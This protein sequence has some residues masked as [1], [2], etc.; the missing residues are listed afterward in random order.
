M[1][2]GEARA[3]PA[4]ATVTPAPCPNCDS[5][6]ENL[7]EYVTAL[8][9]MKQKIV[10]TDHI[11]TEYQKKCDELQKTERE[12]KT[13]RHQMD[14]LLEKC[15][16]VEKCKDE[17]K[18]MRIELEEKKS[19]IK[20]YQQNYSEYTVLKQEQ[21]KHDMLKKKLEARLK[22]LEETTTK[23]NA[24]LKAVKKEKLSLE[25]ALRK[26]QKKLM[27]QQENGI[28]VSKQVQN[29][30]INEQALHTIDKKK[31]KEL[32][33]EVWKCIE[34]P[35]AQTTPD[36]EDV[37]SPA[38]RRSSRIK[39]K[40]R[41]SLFNPSNSSPLEI[42]EL[43]KSL[44]SPQLKCDDEE[45]R[46]H[47]EVDESMNDEGLK[48]ISDRA[49]Y[50]DRTVE[51][52]I[53]KD[54][55][56]CQYISG[57]DTDD[58]DDA[59]QESLSQQ[60]Q[61]ILDW[62]EPLPPQLSPLPCSPSAKEA[63]LSKVQALFG[64]ITDSSDDEAGDVSGGTYNGGDL[65]T[66]TA[67]EPLDVSV[68][69]E[70]PN[71][72]QTPKVEAIILQSVTKGKP[73]RKT[74][75]SDTEMGDLSQSS[76]METETESKLVESELLVPC[77]TAGEIQCKNLQL[78]DEKEVESTVLFQGDVKE[79]NAPAISETQST[80]SAVAHD[81][82]YKDQLP[83]PQHDHGNGGSSAHVGNT[84]VSGDIA[85][86]LISSYQRIELEH[87]RTMPCRKEENGLEAVLQVEKEGE[88][89]LQE[90]RACELNTE[91]M[92]MEE[93]HS[94][95]LPFDTEWVKASV[96]PFVTNAAQT[97]SMAKNEGDEVPHQELESITSACDPIELDK[98]SSTSVIEL[99]GVKSNGFAPVDPEY[100]RRVIPVCEMEHT[101]IQFM[102]KEKTVMVTPLPK[103][104]Y[105]AMTDVVEDKIKECIFRGKNE[106][107]EV[108]SNCGMSDSQKY[109]CRVTSVQ[110]STEL[111][112]TEYTTKERS[113]LHKMES[114]ASFLQ[115]FDHYAAADAAQDQFKVD[116]STDEIEGA[117]LGSFTPHSQN[118]DKSEAMLVEFSDVKQSEPK[119]ER[120][121]SQIVPLPEF[122]CSVQA[123][124]AESS[125]A[126]VAQEE[127][128]TRE[129][130]QLCEM[131]PAVAGRQIMQIVSAEQLPLLPASDCS[132]LSISAQNNFKDCFSNNEVEEVNPSSSI[133]AG[134]DAKSAVASAHTS[135]KQN[136]G[137]FTMREEKDTANLMETLPASDCS[138]VAGLAQ[139]KSM[140]YSSSEDLSK[141]R[142]EPVEF[143][144][145]E[146]LPN[147]RD[148]SVMFNSTEDPANQKDKSVELSS[149]EDLFNQSVKSMEHSFTEQLSHQCEQ[150]DLFT[151]ISEL[152]E[153]STILGVGDS[154]KGVLVEMRTVEE[155]VCENPFCELNE[156]KDQLKKKENEGSNFSNEDGAPRD[157]DNQSSSE[158]KIT[159][160]VR[161]YT[162]ADESE[163][164]NVSLDSVGQECFTEAREKK[165]IDN[166]TDNNVVY[167]KLN[168]NP[169]KSTDL[170]LKSREVPFNDQETL[171]LQPL[172]TAQN[173]ETSEDAQS[174]EPEKPVL[175]LK[176]RSKKHSESM[177]PEESPVE[178]T[179]VNSNEQH[180]TSS[181]KEAGTETA[182]TTENTNCWSE[183]HKADHDVDRF[184]DKCGELR[185]GSQNVPDLKE[186]IFNEEIVAT[187][188][189]EF[190]NIPLDRPIQNVEWSNMELTETTSNLLQIVCAV[191]EL[192]TDADSKE[193]I[194][195]DEDSTDAI[196][197]GCETPPINSGNSKLNIHPIET[198]TEL[199]PKTNTLSECS[200]SGKS[201]LP[202][203]YNSQNKSQGGMDK[204]A[205]SCS[206]TESGLCTK[207]HFSVQMNEENTTTVEEMPGS[208]SYDQIAD[209]STHANETEKKSCS[210]MSTTQKVDSSS[211][212]ELSISSMEHTLN[213]NRD[214]ST[215]ALPAPE[216]E[217][218]E[219]GNGRCELETRSS[220]CSGLWNPTFLN[221]AS[222]T[223]AS[224]EPSM[225]L[226]NKVF[227]STL[228]DPMAAN[229]IEISDCEPI[230][231]KTRKGKKLRLDKDLLL[232]STDKIQNDQQTGSN[233]KKFKV[234]TVKRRV[235]S[236]VKSRGSDHESLLRESQTDT[237]VSPLSAGNIH[238][239]MLE[240]GQPLPPLLAPLV[241]TPPRTTA[242]IRPLIL[243]SNVRSVHSP[244]DELSFSSVE[245]P[246]PCSVSPLFDQARQKSP[247]VHSPSPLDFARNERIQS[248]PLQFCTATPKHAVP[249][250][251][252]LPQSASATVATSLPQENSVKILDAMYPNLS[253][254]ARTL[255]ILRGNVQLSMRGP[256]DGESQAGAVNQI[257]GFKAINSTATAFVKAGNN[258]R[259][260]CR[261]NKERATD[262]EQKQ[263]VVASVTEKGDTPKEEKVAAKRAAENL[264]GKMPKKIKLAQG[265]E[266]ADHPSPIVASNESSTAVAAGT[267]KPF[268]NELAEQKP[269]NK[270]SPEP[271]SL[272]PEQPVKSSEEAVVCALA[273][274]AQSCF[275]LLPV[276]RSHIFVGNIPSLPVLRDE[277]K[278]VISEFSENKELSEALLLAIQ[279]KLKTERLTL[280]INYLHAL[281]RV[282][283]AICRQQGDLERARI[284]CFDILRE[285]F[286]DSDK[287]ILFITSVWKNIFSMRG[288][289][290][291]AMQVVARQRAKDDVL[292]CLTVY[293]D[294]QKN[295]PLNASQ[296]VS[297]FL[298]AM[299]RSPTIKFQAH[300]ELGTDFNSVMWEL[301]FAIDLL[302]SQQPWCLT[303]DNV[304]SK[305][306]WPLM[307]K[308]VK[309]RKGK[310]YVL[311]IQDV[312]VG[313]VLR[314]I[315][316][317]GKHGI[318]KGYTSKVK[319]LS[320]VM[321]L[322]LQQSMKEGVPWSV[323]IAA[324][325]AVYEL[326]PSNLEEALE[327]LKGW[328]ATAIEALPSSVSQYIA[329]LETFC[330]GLNTTT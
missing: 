290:N 244:V 280:D 98:G 87:E 237:S 293:L 90:S 141:Q 26:T 302:C 192:E 62:T 274:L 233:A 47:I 126:E 139:D 150:Q 197:V 212:T 196:S 238:K 218:D 78:E 194:E 282:Y 217:V 71:P 40:L 73:A 158:Q 69:I 55:A 310:A 144:S 215:V 113:P 249:V 201:N 301:I 75:C 65:D 228:D 225:L 169:E 122:N 106:M 134:Q 155:V 219:K 281:C 4:P 161:A 275:D 99:E 294:W 289:L 230:P 154:S 321:N 315:G 309:R 22:K 166:H 13:L 214:P 183:G 132:V 147:M 234:G 329:E 184:I 220:Q 24:D 32:L 207:E 240:M 258:C 72:D 182:P 254:R 110:S 172:C 116:V 74:D 162:F 29:R 253:A 23:Q 168:V 298:V 191:I 241:A 156:E 57:T 56:D 174:L 189:E 107:G 143:G 271:S 264:V 279:E 320:V 268:H 322:F 295:P 67:A 257:V 252:R 82:I 39:S 45:N 103:P 247:S 245:L 312:T 18:T 269:H 216:M 328:K 255:N 42:A 127:C 324:A 209:S 277:E 15:T 267:T 224:G 173:C 175:V 136:W 114:T 303:H 8:I 319:H 104:E 12:C 96:K 14:E 307:D 222:D 273:K 227:E 206:D 149:T 38:E 304:I 251:G 148:K 133:S 9:A 108:N 36:K 94:N 5:L 278:Q 170:A 37:Y 79:S 52:T 325:Q 46:F 2:P 81:A 35:S 58:D 163:G 120:K 283:T 235:T 28:K 270:A 130:K 88:I 41:N 27:D 229:T 70:P 203:N 97:E 300:E 236:R 223:G 115:E 140:D 105:S 84:E 100:E 288:P 266:N 117:S 10:E 48:N 190:I 129:R 317:L 187:S 208:I 286:P 185:L 109:S 272:P 296:L 145:T 153:E 256:P 179:E 89:L 146:D 16:L 61:E 137:E 121:K 323:Q 259:S 305:E 261:M 83:S 318:T 43:S 311:H 299:Q 111:I 44:P 101:K 118:G 226:K 17:M 306:L 276:I 124:A 59:E 7:N 85:D 6:R 50:D 31:V 167:S 314:L 178:A 204:S 199:L 186:S 176:V 200:E 119:S 243:A 285:D 242:R 68:C 308:W 142:V 19:S 123:G 151:V 80:D 112:H 60:L 213:I 125:D 232:T 102:T 221:D 53:Q 66:G 20:M 202:A 260:E 198:W 34:K 160:C 91:P 210:C 64:N 263:L 171:S 25:K 92:E 181:H 205:G 138:V 262:P 49:F 128:S 231:R 195:A 297:S 152:R 313:A 159:D 157:L 246:K 76:L 63:R 327:T 188:E 54:P 135:P 51:L 326:A 248:S 11:L 3:A 95:T 177:T 77:L 239:V 250:P 164:P 1:M 193:N 291:K 33:E 284:L 211:Q 86:S 287:L 292:Q 165:P 21:A 316:R 330:E 131:K 265:V 30:K 180:R 93:V